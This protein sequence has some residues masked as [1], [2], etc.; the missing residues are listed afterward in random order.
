MNFENFSRPLGDSKKKDVEFVDLA[1]LRI[2]V[3]SKW[4]PAIFKGGRIY[5]KE[6]SYKN[7][8]S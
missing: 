6:E 3:N 1:D 7:L 2:K 4:I 5:I 8:F